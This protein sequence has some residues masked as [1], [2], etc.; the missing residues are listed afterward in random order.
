MMGAARG[1]S[2]SGVA[3]ILVLAAIATAA[4]L[5]LW[6]QARALHR[7]AGS[8]A[9]LETEQLRLTAAET[10]RAA[11]Y[12]LAADP[13]LN[14]DHP[15][16]DWAQIL[17]R[18]WGDGIRSWAQVEDAA[19]QVNLNNLA[20]ADQPSR[21][22][23]EIIRNAFS[24]CGHFE[25]DAPVAALSDYLDA[26]QDG[27]FEAAFY[28]HA[29]RP[30]T[31]P[32]RAL[33][34]AADLLDV[35]GF[36]AALFA[37]PDPA[38]RQR[39]ELFG[40]DFRLAVTLVPDASDAPIPVNVNTATREALLSVAGVEHADTV[41]SAMALRA[42]HPF[43][44]LSLLFAAS[45]ELAAALEGAIDVK[46]S[47]YRVRATAERNGRRRSVVAWARRETDGSVHLLQWLEGV[48]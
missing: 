42:L 41:R 32:D 1:S 34:G 5:L 37:P 29:D 16:E 39:D 20:A 38:R 21:T 11:L 23:A 4:G 25:S 44:S 36:T 28:R 45:P 40:G 18:D 30:Q 47:Y 10:A 24:C 46:S 7:G 19:A 14:V 15:G 31:P 6:L 2:R 13:D 43:Q 17:E 48:S 33:W 12:V 35:H 27:P 9:A 26:D 22:F 3:M 8:A